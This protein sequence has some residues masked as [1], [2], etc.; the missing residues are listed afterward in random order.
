[1]SGVTRIEITD[2]RW[3]NPVRAGYWLAKWPLD[4]GRFKQ[5]LFSIQKYGERGAYRRAVRA[6]TAALAVLA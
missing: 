5:C 1:V 6:R 2:R 3:K 4:G